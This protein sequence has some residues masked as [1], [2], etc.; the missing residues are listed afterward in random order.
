MRWLIGLPV[1]APLPS[2][3]TSP[4]VAALALEDGVPVDVVDDRSE[5]VEAVHNVVIQLPL[6]HHRSLQ[7]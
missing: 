1:L 2:C 4:A 7:V 6:R 5:V 3:R